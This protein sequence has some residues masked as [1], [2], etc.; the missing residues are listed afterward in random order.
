MQKIT[1]FPWFDSQAEEAAEFYVAVFRAR[2]AAH[3]GGGD[4]GILEVSRYGEA[5]PGAPGSAMTIRFVLDGQEFIA[6][7]G[8]PLFPFTEAVSLS[9]A[10]ADQAEVDQLWA[11]LT[12]GGE[13]VQCGWLKDRYGLSWQINPTRL[14]ELLGDPDPERARRATEAMLKMK[15]ID[16]AALERAAAGG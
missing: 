10:C 15:R 8:G 6:L 4:S 2:R 11:A 13:E 1:T 9:V 16:I 12:D 5:G 3:G 7:N 14:G